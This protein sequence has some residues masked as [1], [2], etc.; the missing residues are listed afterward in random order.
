M[1]TFKD[2]LTKIAAGEDLEESEAEF[3]LEEIVNGNVSD[4][5]IAA[6]LFGMRMKG[7][8]P[9]EMTVFVKV[10]REK[11]VKV[12]VDTGKAVDLCGTGGDHSGTFNISTS[13]MFVAAGAGV[14]VLKHGNR[15][16]SSK[17]GSADVI[18]ALGGVAELR[19][20]QVEQ[21]FSETGIAFMYAPFFHPAMKH[22]MP[23]R[24]A[25]GMRS[26]FNVL[27]PLL[28]P[29]D[30]R[31]QIV[32]AFNKQTAHL[33]AQILSNLDTEFAYTVNAEDGLD[34]I[35]LSADSQLY[36]VS[37]SMVSDAV[38]FSP[39]TLNFDRIELA[40]L[41]GGDAQYNAIIITD[42]VDNKATKAQKNIAVVN[43]AFGIHAAR[44]T[45]SLS[46]AKEVAEESIASG[47]ARKALDDF[48]EAT[49]NV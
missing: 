41:Q 9:T 27:G 36:E 6:F 37:N 31:H 13:A 14:P 20:E 10:M 30:V 19:K 45:E 35:S 26:F 32:G 2:I 38:R 8:T 34:E 46:E 42:I 22:V 44:I 43:A 25:L 49:N 11:A 24:R 33:I 7:E 16:V 1:Q 15:S 4:I 18:E 3:A 17:S 39:E 48:V 5:H 28:N 12:S 21:V 29:A 23:A 40:D 47:A